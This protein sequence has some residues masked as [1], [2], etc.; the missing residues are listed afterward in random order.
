MAST[1]PSPR[2]GAVVRGPASVPEPAYETRLRDGR[3]EVRLLEIHC[4]RAAR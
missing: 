1:Q 4:E 2:D 3:V